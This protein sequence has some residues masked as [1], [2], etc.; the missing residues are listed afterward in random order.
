MYTPSV[1]IYSCSDSQLSVNNHKLVQHVT[2]IAIATCMY[3]D[4]IWAG[5]QHKSDTSSCPVEKKEKKNVE[6]KE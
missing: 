2:C 3:C 6:K 1:A 5:S 4:A